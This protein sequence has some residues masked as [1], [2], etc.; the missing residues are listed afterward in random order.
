MPATS[1]DVART[2]DVWRMLV[3]S[4]SRRI[5]R[6]RMSN[7]LVAGDDAGGMA[8]GPVVRRVAVLLALVVV[9]LAVASALHLSGRVHGR[10]A[11]FDAEHAGIAEALIGAVLGSAVVALW[12]AGLRARRAGLWGVVFAIAGFCWGLNITARG[13]HWP[14]IGYHLVVLPLLVASFVPL[15]RAGR[16]VAR[17]DQLS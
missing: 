2:V 9:S 12:R 11:P 6:M 5:G 13:G 7:L 8:G 17:H 14:D 4:L 1:G 16:P 15:L 3:I 10:G